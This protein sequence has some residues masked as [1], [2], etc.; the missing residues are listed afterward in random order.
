MIEARLSV[1]QVDPR[2]A[3]EV[4]PG[5]RI[6][7]LG[8]FALNILLSIGI[9]RWQVA[10][11]PVRSM[12]AVACLA[13][14]VATAPR[15][16]LDTIRRSFLILAVVLGF[17]LVGAAVTLLYGDSWAMIGRQ[18]AEIHLQACFGYILAASVVQVC[19][20]RSTV[21]IFLSMIAVSVTIAVLQFMHVD[22]AWQARATLGRFQ[23]EP[24][25]TQLFYTRRERPL[26]ISYT[27]VHLGT[28]ACLGFAAFYAWRLYDRARFGLKGL[29][30]WVLAALAVMVGVCFVSGNRSPILGAIAFV[31]IYLMITAPRLFWIAVPF[32]VVAIPGLLALQPILAGAGVRIANI[33]DGSAMGRA[34]L[35][36]YGWRLFTSRPIGY[37]FGFDSTQH[38]SDYWQYM[39][40]YANPEQIR[41]FAPHN[42][43]I[44]MLNKYGLGALLLLPLIIPRT[45]GA[46]A[47]ALPFLAYLLHILFHNDGP[48]LA[49]FLFWYVVA[50]FNP[51]VATINT[52]LNR[53]GKNTESGWSG[54]AIKPRFSTWRRS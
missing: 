30:P 44:I 47:A 32:A 34:V 2:H 51:A 9:V 7:I 38:W 12:L 10:S 11:I 37:G 40:Y 53:V 1:Q 45:R 24:P 14:L 20:V 41:R 4:S 18:L 54:F 3:G 29:D 31:A 49:D 35:A 16:V 23:N 28:Q 5:A 43:A 19:G 21:L 33:N 15:A 50:M 36:D 22:A 25:I 6:F 39:L 26:G 42:Y 46:W 13:L 48:L 17:A 52:K 27:P 8:L